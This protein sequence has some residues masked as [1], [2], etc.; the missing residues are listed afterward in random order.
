[1]AHLHTLSVA[2]TRKLRQNRIAKVRCWKNN[3]SD[4]DNNKNNKKN[5]TKRKKTMLAKKMTK[6]QKEETT[7]KYTVSPAEWSVNSKQNFHHSTPLPL[8]KNR[9]STPSYQNQPKIYAEI[10]L[11]ILSPFLCL[12]HPIRLLKNV[13]KKKLKIQVRLKKREWKKLVKKVFL[14]TKQK[15]LRS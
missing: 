12:L 6:K 14:K 9:F 10:F 4:N 7:A 5:V 8:V 11:L 3:I 15:N 13:S 2:L 1:M